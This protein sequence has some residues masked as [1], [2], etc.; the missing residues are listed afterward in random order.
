MIFSERWTAGS[1]KAENNDMKDHDIPVTTAV[2]ALRSAGVP[3]I[4]HF[5]DYVDH[6]GTKHAAE[7]LGWDEHAVIKTLVME[8]HDAKK[9]FVVVLMHGNRE[10]S[11]KQLARIL[12]VKTVS[13]ASE[14]DV[15]KNTGYVPGGVSPFGTRGR[16][17]VYVEESILALEKILINGGKRGF[18]VEIKTTELSRVLKTIPVQV[19]IERRS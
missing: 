1:G 7:S 19:S 9:R 2:R 3:V 6:G 8:V 15:E 4:P 11:T 10:V 16:L 18:L 12:D 13:P 5:Y 17:P 14:A